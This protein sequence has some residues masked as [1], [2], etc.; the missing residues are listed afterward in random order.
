M[1]DTFAI[2][3]PYAYRCPVKHLADG[4]PGCDPCDM[5][6][7]ERG[8]E[9]FDADGAGSL[10]GTIAEP[11]LSAGGVIDPPPGYL[12]RLAE[13]T[14]ASGGLFIVDEAQMDFGRLGTMF[15]FE[16]DAIVPDIVTVLKTLGGGLPLAAT[17]ISPE[18]EER[19]FERGF[20]HVHVSDPLPSAWR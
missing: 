10:A 6:C 15:G 3:A 8:L 11:V 7:L 19:I 18:I 13:T 17:V 14:R 16:Q 20:I 2:P 5:S 4:T 9:L 12:R 1:P